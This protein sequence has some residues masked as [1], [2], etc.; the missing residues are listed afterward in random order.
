MLKITTNNQCPKKISQKKIPTE[1]KLF[2]INNNSSNN[3]IFLTSYS[4]NNS[5]SQL[6]NE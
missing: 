3:Y 2:L 4:Y 6:M 1:S 5:S